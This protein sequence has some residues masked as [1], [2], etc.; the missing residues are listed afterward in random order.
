M[1]ERKPIV[2][3]DGDLQELP[4]GDTLPGSG[5]VGMIQSE[6]ITT[7]YSTI[8]ADF[9]GNVIRRMNNVSA[10]TITVEPSMT[11][12][13]PVTFIATGAGAVSFVAGTGV[14][15]NSADGNL[16]IAAQYG[17]ASL[18]PDVDTADTYYLVGHLAT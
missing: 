8:N 13:Q 3:I 18:I 17:S 14:T 15:I 10:Q 16:S 5:G 9:A 2:I 11:G 1:A 7:T 12:G 6:I 4:T